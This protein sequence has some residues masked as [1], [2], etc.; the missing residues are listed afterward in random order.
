MYKK[1]V[2]NYDNP[3]RITV[4]LDHMNVNDVIVYFN[5]QEIK[6]ISTN[7]TTLLNNDKTFYPS[8]NF[9]VDS[10]NSENSLK[11]FVVLSQGIT[12]SAECSDYL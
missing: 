9:E 8:F 2:L 5:N 12:V 3:A 11:V 10:V 4:Y 1:T 6:S 7:F